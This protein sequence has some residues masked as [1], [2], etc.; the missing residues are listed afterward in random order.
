MPVPHKVD[1]PPAMSVTE[2]PGFTPL[3]SPSAR[4]E[5]AAGRLV[6]IERGEPIPTETH[7]AVAREEPVLEIDNFCLWYGPKQALHNVALRIP[8]GKVTALIGPSGCGKSTLLRSVNRMNDL[9]DIVRITGNMRLNG[10]PIYS[11]AVD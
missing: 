3:G 9:L 11:P 5:R 2:R 8:R 10:D 4:E 6:A 7:G 1:A